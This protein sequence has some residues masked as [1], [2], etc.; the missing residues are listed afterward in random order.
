MFGC[1][2]PATPRGMGPKRAELCRSVLKWSRPRNEPKCVVSAHFGHISSTTDGPGE[3]QG[4]RS[5]PY[6]RRNMPKH[7]GR[8]GHQGGA[9]VMRR[10]LTSSG[11][12]HTSSSSLASPS[13]ELIWYTFESAVECG[14]VVG[15]FP[16][17]STLP[18][19]E[20]SQ[21]TKGK[22]QEKNQ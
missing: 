15:G 3:G 19:P 17:C 20:S 4:E 1:A 13:P 11:S 21:P 2:H 5:G 10:F 7:A 8:E 9:P 16:C 6:L 12:A 18:N 14:T 22:T